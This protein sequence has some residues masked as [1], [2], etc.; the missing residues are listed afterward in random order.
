ML[1]TILQFFLYTLANEQLVCINFILI[2]FISKVIIVVFP[3]NGIAPSSEPLVNQSIVQQVIFNTKCNM[4]ELMHLLTKALRF[5]VSVE[6]QNKFINT[7]EAKFNFYIIL[8]LIILLKLTKIINN[9]RYHC[10]E[11]GEVTRCCLTKRK[12]KEKKKKK[13]TIYLV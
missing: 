12:K 1:P 4:R 5:I 10:F 13:K 9:R 3:W 11:A 7:E 8:K 6:H 2:W